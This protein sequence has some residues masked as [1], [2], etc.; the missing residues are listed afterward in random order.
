MKKYLLPYLLAG[1]ALLASMQT[2][3]FACNALFTPD[4]PEWKA[5]MS[6]C[7]VIPIPGV[8]SICL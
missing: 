4:S 7:K 5:C 8:P 1:T 2:Y 6:V 3:A